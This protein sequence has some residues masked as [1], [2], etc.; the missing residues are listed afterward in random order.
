V[1]KPSMNPNR[2]PSPVLPTSLQQAKARRPVTLFPKPE[3]RLLPDVEG[4]RSYANVNNRLEVNLRGGAETYDVALAVPTA[5]F[6]LARDHL[7][8]SREE[9]I[10]LAIDALGKE[11]IRWY[12]FSA[13]SSADRLFDLWLYT[14]ST[15]PAWIMEPAYRLGPGAT[16]YHA[17]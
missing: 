14:P 3:W 2:V 7:K 17:N 9:Q 5:W 10:T 16:A 11:R 13:M 1:I 15:L 8:I 12:I 6:T 4:V